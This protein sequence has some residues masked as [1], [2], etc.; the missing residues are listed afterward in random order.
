LPAVTEMLHLVSRN[1]RVIEATK[2]DRRNVEHN[3]G[4]TGLSG[5]CDL[6]Q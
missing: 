1:A 2:C 3:M 5:C 4:S 6:G